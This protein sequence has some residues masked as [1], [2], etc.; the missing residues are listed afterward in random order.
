MYSFDSYVRAAHK[1]E[2]NVNDH[3][4]IPDDDDVNAVEF[5]READDAIREA[6][7]SDD[8]DHSDSDSDAPLPLANEYKA[9]NPQHAEIKNIREAIANFL[10]P[11]SKEKLRLLANKTSDDL[12]S[13][14][15][16]TRCWCGC[17]NP[18]DIMGVFERADL[19]SLKFIVEEKLLHPAMLCSILAKTFSSTGT[20][21]YPAREIYK[22]KLLGKDY[23]KEMSD[24]DAAAGRDRTCA[25][26]LELATANVDFLLDYLCKEH[27]KLVA[28]WRHHDPKNEDAG[29]TLLHH[30]FYGHTGDEEILRWVRKLLAA[31]CSPFAFYNFDTGSY[32]T[33]FL[34]MLRHL[35]YDLAIEMTQRSDA[36]N[37]A[38]LIN[39]IDKFDVKHDNRSALQ[40]IL[41]RRKCTKNPEW[42][43][44]VR[45]VINLI[46]KLG[47]NMDHRDKNGMNVSDYI[48]QYGYSNL[49]ADDLL[50]YN[51]PKP[52]GNKPKVDKWKRD[53]QHN[54]SPY[55]ALF[56]KHRYAKTQ[57]EID[58]L[59]AEYEMLKTSV[60]P[61][62]KEQ[63][64]DT[65]RL[66]GMDYSP[67]SS[68]IHSYWS[69]YQV[70]PELGH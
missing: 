16:S 59:L 28:E 56:F 61:L 39:Y 58:G 9:D 29:G 52:T 48:E 44:D 7:H 68:L 60:G 3:E 49:L 46:I 27:P 57:L 11:D 67:L 19:D 24:L 6:P 66:Q 1:I 26:W 30:V 55:A 62:T 63:L 65:G 64:A 69:I 18:V 45:K 32:Q 54:P 14:Y 25:G 21:S 4:S 43:A 47:V 41:Y 42:N 20:L 38:V 53:Q 23:E 50:N 36:P 2:D 33:P 34:L 51:L 31:G 15:N 35:Y 8:E 22:Y 70:I 10:L 17:S 37:F 40:T 12:T 5:A 13:G